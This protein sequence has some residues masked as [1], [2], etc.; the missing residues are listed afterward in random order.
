MDKIR[1]KILREQ[2]IQKA[3]LNAHFDKA[4]SANGTVN[5]KG[6]GVEETATKSANEVHDENK[7]QSVIKAVEI[8]GVDNA[9]DILKSAGNEDLF[10]KSR[11]GTYADTSENRKLGRVGQKYGEV[12]RSES[13]E[14]RRG[15][16][17]LVELPNKGEVVVSYVEQMWNPK[18]HRV[19]YDGKEYIITEDKIKNDSPS[20]SRK[21]NETKIKSQIREL[22][23]RLKE[24][25]S[26]MENDPDVSPEDDFYSYKV[27]GK[28]IEKIENKIANLRNK[29]NG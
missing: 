25:R 26:D 23:I 8:D 1:E 2:E 19:K 21:I 20:S 13:G 17:L 11:S 28:E 16:K 18:N 29:L 5:K 9:L 12:K 7:R 24:L 27:Y 22:S 10:E 14:Y 3:R 6:R 4:F 15:K